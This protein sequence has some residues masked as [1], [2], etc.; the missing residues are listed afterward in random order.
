MNKNSTAII[1]LLSLFTLMMQA[2]L[3]LGTITSIWVFS[4][5][6]VGKQAVLSTILEHVDLKNSS[7]TSNSYVAFYLVI[8]FFGILMLFLYL[9]CIRR[10]LQNINEKIY[11]EEKNLN[12]IKRTLIFFSSYTFA[13]FGMELVHRVFNVIPLY[14]LTASQSYSWLGIF[15]GL[16]TV[17][18]I[19]VIYV[20]FRQGVLLKKENQS[21]V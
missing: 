19:Y 14:D 1:G 6:P 8:Y 3:F 10:L 15:D 5:F 11:F 13:N 21:I 2:F 4:S 18:G 7:L 12:L 9:N 16:V 17:M 20:V